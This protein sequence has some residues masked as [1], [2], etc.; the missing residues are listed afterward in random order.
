[1]QGSNASGLQGGV[2][3]FTKGT[4][5]ASLEIKGFSHQPGT[6]LAASKDYILSLRFID[7]HLNDTQETKL[8]NER[9]RVLGNADDNLTLRYW[10]Q[11][12]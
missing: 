4:V 3:I 6:A 1:M 9:R 10:L 8:F 5:K 2:M 12:P 7:E 11:H